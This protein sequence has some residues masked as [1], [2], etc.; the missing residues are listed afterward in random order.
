MICDAYLNLLSHVKKRW[1][2]GDI[3]AG[4]R[5]LAHRIPYP[6]DGNC[7]W[8]PAEFDL[9][10]IPST[11]QIFELMRLTFVMSAEGHMGLA[12]SLGEDGRHHLHIG[13]SSDALYSSTQQQQQHDVPILGVWV[14]SWYYGW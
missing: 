1:L 4:L 12:P 6:Y 10:Y 2:K 13:R 8:I 14:Y 7:D 11:L 9:T 3:A 5:A